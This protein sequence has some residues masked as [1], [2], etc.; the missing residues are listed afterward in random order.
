MYSFF[1]FR[2]NSSSFSSFLSYEAD[3]IDD[4]PSLPTVLLLE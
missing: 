4:F 2:V 1:Y 3:S